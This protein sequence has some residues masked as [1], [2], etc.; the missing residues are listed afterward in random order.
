MHFYVFILVFNSQKH[1]AHFTFYVSKSTFFP[2]KTGSS[3]YGEVIADGCFSLRYAFT[4]E[5]RRVRTQRNAFD[6]GE[7]EHTEECLVIKNSDGRNG[8]V[9]SN[10]FAQRNSGKANMWKCIAKTWNAFWSLNGFHFKDVHIANT[11]TITL[12]CPLLEFSKAWQNICRERMSF[13]DNRLQVTK[14]R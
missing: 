2:T 1:C 14:L 13:Q 6:R 4:Y 10:R 8:W 7:W 5:M 11:C 12:L 3:S 9:T